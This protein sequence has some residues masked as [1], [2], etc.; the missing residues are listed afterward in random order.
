MKKLISFISFLTF[1][2][3]LGFA[4]NNDN[5][6]ILNKMDKSL[7]YSLGLVDA[8]KIIDDPFSHAFLEI[9][10]G[11][12]IKGT[13]AH[14]KI[15]EKNLSYVNQ[16]DFPYDVLLYVHAGSKPK[17]NDTIYIYRIMAQGKSVIIRAKEIKGGLVI[18]PQTQI[19]FNIKGNVVKNDIVPSG[20]LAYPAKGVI[21]SQ[22]DANNNNQGTQEADAQSKKKEKNR[23]MPAEFALTDSEK[24]QYPIL[25][26]PTVQQ[27]IQ[28]K[29]VKKET[30][31]QYKGK[32]L[33]SYQILGIG[34]S[35]SANGV[36]GAVA[37]L[38]EAINALNDQTIG[39]ST[40]KA[41]LHQFVTNAQENLF[42]K[43]IENGEVES[44]K[45]FID[46]GV[47][48]RSLNENGE[49]P[50]Y[51][52]AAKEHKDIAQLIYDK[53][54]GTSLDAL[55]LAIQNDKKQAEQII[56]E[57]SRVNAKNMFK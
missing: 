26:L 49:T 34:S 32:N 21:K 3:S 51:L 52:A 7:W 46:A 17:Q 40:Q 12:M 31:I 55:F 37:E 20:V 56:R 15:S 5:L 28:N 30:I 4:T 9:K 24:R 57:V 44:A 16:K 41:L 42:F 25:L 33:N 35:A 36:N 43:A 2:G 14:G 48:L 6:E 50:L 38:N 23:E 13:I 19:G 11:K 1:F 53:D 29:A 22:G 45:V 39:G 27:L 18:E 54:S 47:N 10:P 8:K